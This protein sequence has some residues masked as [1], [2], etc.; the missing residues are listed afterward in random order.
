MSIEDSEKLTLLE[1]GKITDKLVIKIITENQNK[2]VLK[3]FAT[4]SYDAFGNYRFMLIYVIDLTEEYLKKQDQTI[5]DLLV[6]KMNCQFGTGNFIISPYRGTFITREAANVTNLNFCKD[7]TSELNLKSFQNYDSETTSKEFR[8]K[9]K[10]DGEYNI[11]IEKLYNGEID[12]N[13][14]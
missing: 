2:K 12:K 6:Y 10:D 7:L 1:E 8:K 4:P 13:R 11:Q 14:S 5:L 9:I 3:F